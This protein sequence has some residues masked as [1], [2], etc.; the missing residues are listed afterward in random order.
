MNLTDISLPNIIT[1]LFDAPIAT[2]KLA[3]DE[4]VH[5]P[6]ILMLYG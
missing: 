3:A 4:P 1:G 2:A 5:A 6:R